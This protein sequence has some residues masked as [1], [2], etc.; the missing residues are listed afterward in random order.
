M[1]FSYISTKQKFIDIYC[2]LEILNMADNSANLPGRRL[3]FS[4]FLFL[5]AISFAECNHND[6][7]SEELFIKPFSSGHVMFHFQLTTVWNVSIDKPDLC[8]Y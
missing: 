7:F 4:L 5:I 6:R 1:F 2:V 3:N 8:K